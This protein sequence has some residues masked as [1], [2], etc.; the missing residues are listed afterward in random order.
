MHFESLLVL[1]TASSLHNYP[2][3]TVCFFLGIIIFSLLFRGLLSLLRAFFFTVVF[4]LVFLLLLAFFLL[5]LF[6]S[7]VLFVFLLRLSQN[8]FIA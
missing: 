8:V 5:A 6:A 7:S 1:L 2:F 4:P 3:P